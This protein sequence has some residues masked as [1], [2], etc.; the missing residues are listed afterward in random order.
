MIPAASIRRLPAGPGGVVTANYTSV[1]QPR[2]QTLAVGN[3]VS[4]SGL[5]N[6]RNMSQNIATG[7][8]T[9]GIIVRTGNNRNNQ[10]R[11]TMPST[12]G[13]LS[14]AASPAQNIHSRGETSIRRIIVQM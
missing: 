3:N 5:N 8:G 2:N 1:A 12:Q 14:Y 11:A 4:N 9:Q 6:V 7:V 13:G 10:Q